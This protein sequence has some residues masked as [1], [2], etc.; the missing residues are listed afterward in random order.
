MKKSIAILAI[1]FTMAGQA[2]VSKVT[3]QA[4]GLTCSLC[5][6]A[7]NKALKSVPYIDNV[8]PNI[9]Q[10]SFE[11]TFKPGASVHFDDLK[12]KVEDAGFFVARFTATMQFDNIPVSPDAHVNIGG[13]MVHF[14]H[15]KDKVLSGE[16]VIQV[17]DKGYVSAKEFRKNAVFTK[18][19]CYKTGVAGSCCTK[20]GT[21]AGTRI[22]HITI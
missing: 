16:Q 12:K 11:V 1:L 13:M 22:Y 8:T 21:T 5:S 19:D 4:S 2:Q 9:K 18:M 6:N 14:L 10:S 7:I 20:S 3:I 15:V 17:L